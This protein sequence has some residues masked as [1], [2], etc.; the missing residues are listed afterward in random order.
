VKQQKTLF[1]L[2]SRE[3]RRAFY[4]DFVVPPSFAKPRG[5]SLFEYYLSSLLTAKQ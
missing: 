2:H 1:I 3:G 5:I 4:A